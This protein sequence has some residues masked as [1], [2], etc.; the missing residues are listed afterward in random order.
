M[1]LSCPFKRQEMWERVRESQW[2]VLMI[3]ADAFISGDEVRRLFMETSPP[4]AFSQEEKATTAAELSR[5]LK[6]GTEVAH[7]L[8][9]ST[10]FVRRYVVWAV[11]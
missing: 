1:G 9:E 6:S 3:A 10:D 7:A 4:I 2:D 11:S 5:R 8:A